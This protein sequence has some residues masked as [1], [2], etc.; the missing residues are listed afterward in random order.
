MVKRATLIISAVIFATVMG[1]FASLGADNAEGAWT[2]KDTTGRPFTITL[3]ADGT[4]TSTLRPDMIGTWTEQGQSVVI[5]WKTGWTT[6][7]AKANGRYTHSA[8]RE[9]QSLDGPPASTSD[10]QKVK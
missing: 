8:Y 5:S 1:C 7:I 3:F 9:G 4:A 10:A 2:V 6:K